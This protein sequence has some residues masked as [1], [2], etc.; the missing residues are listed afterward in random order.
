MK[1]WLR[2]K[3]LVNDGE[4]SKAARDIDGAGVAEPTEKVIAEL[5]GKY[6][7]RSDEVEW[8]KIAAVLEELK[9]QSKADLIESKKTVISEKIQQVA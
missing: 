1:R 5:I 7:K 6:P 9:E 4:M 8:P 3:R 2:V